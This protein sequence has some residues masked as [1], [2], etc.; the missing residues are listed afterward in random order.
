[1]FSNNHFSQKIKSTYQSILDFI[2]PRSQFIK[3][4]EKLSTY[5]LYTQTDKS[6]DE[7]SWI[8]SLF[9]Y[10]DP[11][12]KQAIREIKYHKNT[13]IIHTCS[14]LLYEK[15]L[16]DLG[17]SLEFNQTKHNKNII[18]LPVPSTPPEKRNR[19]YNQSELLVKHICSQDTSNTFHNGSKYIY[20]V[21]DTK[22]QNKTK[23]R[24][25]RK[26]NIRNCFSIDQ[27]EFSK[28][29]HVIIID[30]VYTTGSTLYEIKKILSQ[31]TRNISAYTIAH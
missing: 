10:K 23:N 11:L 30:D 15:I 31:C 18:I 2:F 13:Q 21:R 19:G 29:A 1:M 25:E 14:I 3:K 27:S 6:I 26:R 7:H 12:I 9:D 22:A 28:D 8:H 20:K 24:E 5:E 16:N 4:L 17:D